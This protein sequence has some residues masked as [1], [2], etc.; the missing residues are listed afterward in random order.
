MLFDENMSDPR[1]AARHRARGHDP[2][3]APDVGLL[4]ATDPRML[5]FAIAEYSGF[6]PRFRRL[7]RPP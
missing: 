4:S 3:L 1:L 7:R 5:I 6:D 2:I